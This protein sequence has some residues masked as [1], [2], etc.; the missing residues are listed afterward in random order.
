MA[1]MITHN[2]TTRWKCFF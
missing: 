1:Q 2:P